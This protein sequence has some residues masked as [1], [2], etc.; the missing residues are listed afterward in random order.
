MRTRRPSVSAPVDRRTGEKV[1]EHVEPNSSSGT[2]LQGTWATPTIAR[3]GGRD[4]LILPFP[5]VIKGFD[6]AT[7]GELWQTKGPGNFVYG[8]ALFADGLAVFGKSVLKLQP[9]GASEQRR[10][11]RS[12]G[13]RGPH[14]GIFSGGYLYVA[15]AIPSCFE[16]ATGKE[17]WKDQIKQRPGTTSAWGSLVLAGDKL[18]CTDQAGTTLV[19]AAGPKYEVLAKNPLKEHCNASLAVSQGDIFIRTWKH[20]WRIGKGD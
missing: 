1:W 4:Q 14:S 6:P 11:E 9:D 12:G 20:L 7:G 5:Y 2:N 13:G 15:D 19:L 3:V 18:Y 8:S 16:I 10:L 17:I